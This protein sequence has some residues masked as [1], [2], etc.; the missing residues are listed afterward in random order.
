MIDSDV[1]GGLQASNPPLAPQGSDASAQ[2]VSAPAKTRSFWKPVIAGAAFLAFFAGEAVLHLGFEA[3]DAG[4]SAVAHGARAQAQFAKDP[5]R[6]AERPPLA[7]VADAMGAKAPTAPAS[8]AGMTLRPTRS[9]ETQALADERLPVNLRDYSRPNPLA[10][11]VDANLAA[12]ALSG[13]LNAFSIAQPANGQNLTQGELAEWERQALSSSP[14]LSGFSGPS[15]GNPVLLAPSWA[16][17]SAFVVARAARVGWGLQIQWASAAQC[18]IGQGAIAQV[19]AFARH[20]RAVDG[21]TLCSVSSGA[22]PAEIFV[23][24]AAEDARSIPTIGV[25]MDRVPAGPG[26]AL[27]TTPIDPA[28]T[29]RNHRGPLDSEA[30]LAQ[31]DHAWPPVATPAAF[32][33]VLEISGDHAQS[34]DWR[35]LPALFAASREAEKSWGPADGHWDASSIGQ[36]WISALKTH[37][38]IAPPASTLDPSDPAALPALLA[39]FQKPFSLRFSPLARPPLSPLSGARPSLAPAAFDEASPPARRVSPKTAT[40]SLSAIS[41][42]SF[43]LRHLPAFGWGV[44]ATIPPR[45]CQ[46]VMAALQASSPAR[47]ARVDET[48]DTVSGD[49]DPV[50]CSLDA[51][52]TLFAAFDDLGASGQAAYS[53]APHSL[54]DAALSESARAT[55]GPNPLTHAPGQA[56][57]KE[58]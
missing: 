10:Y 40:V 31:R 46:A 15:L 19:P 52:T 56:G 22:A 41:G 9:V 43:A 26:D 20:S 25:P 11:I 35:A 51:P 54:A 38:L 5:S 24:F 42:S 14:A 3:A 49:G 48:L 44:Q 4:S 36:E 18:Q 32:A 53:A 17:G 2:A 12:S 13:A 50:V 57:R 16:P 45:S 33:P 28:D 1:P 23:S 27:D 39:Q 6:V 29:I 34:P 8:R 30:L 7:A 55:A 58:R 47:V 21:S 37:G